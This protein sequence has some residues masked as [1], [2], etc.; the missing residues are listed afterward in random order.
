MQLHMEIGNILMTI[1]ELNT[2]RTKEK[3]SLV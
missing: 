3:V 1:Q 2:M